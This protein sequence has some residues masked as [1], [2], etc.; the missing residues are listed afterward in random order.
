MVDKAPGRRP[1]TATQARIAVAPKAGFVYHRG[2]RYLA[3]TARLPAD[4]LVNA[5]RIVEGM[6]GD[7][8]LEP[9]TSRM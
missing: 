8:G 6:V 1:A 3:E 9:V 2:R 7:T 4:G 5:D